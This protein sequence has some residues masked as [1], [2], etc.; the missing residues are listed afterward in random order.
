M[1]DTSVALGPPEMVRFTISSWKFCYRI[2]QLEVQILQREPF[3]EL[4]CSTVALR[5]LFP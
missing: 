3:V 4:M 2:T 5:S 1:I